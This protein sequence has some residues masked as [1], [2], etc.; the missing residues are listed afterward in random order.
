MS[1]IY[2]VHLADSSH[3]QACAMCGLVLHLR[4][5]VMKSSSDCSEA[6]REHILERK[7]REYRDMV[8]NYY[9]IQA[10]ERSAEDDTALRQVRHSPTHIKSMQYPLIQHLCQRQTL[11]TVITTTKAWYLKICPPFSGQSHHHAADGA[12][13]IGWPGLSVLTCCCLGRSLLTCQGRPQACHSSRRG[14]CRRAWSASCTSGASGDAPLEAGMTFGLA[15]HSLSHCAAPCCLTG[16]CCEVLTN[17]LAC[18]RGPH[19]LV[20][21]PDLPSARSPMWECWQR[22]AVCVL[23]ATCHWQVDPSQAAGAGTLPAAMCRASMTWSRP[24]WQCS[25][26]RTWR[27][28]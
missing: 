23:H 27:V 21:V 9:D 22:L 5:C 11:Q 18:L 12:P 7:R 2:G 20:A 4:S 3:W 16:S 24:S 19:Q 1:H 28:L 26:R 6:C 8:P 14:S 10:A 13:L 17:T 15:Q 25:C